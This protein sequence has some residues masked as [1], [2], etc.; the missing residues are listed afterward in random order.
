M[1]RERAEQC[2]DKLRIL[3][4]KPAEAF[5][6]PFTAKKI[7]SLFSEILWKWAACFQ[8]HDNFI[9]QRSV[10]NKSNNN[11]CISIFNN[12]IIFEISQI[13]YFIWFT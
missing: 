7:P 13:L 2:T 9:S 12:Q 10:F 8:S 6:N 5:Q 3:L 1:E 4:V 11:Y